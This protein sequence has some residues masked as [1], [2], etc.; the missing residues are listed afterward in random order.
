[1]ILNDEDEDEVLKEGYASKWLAILS[2]LID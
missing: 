1:V 2:W